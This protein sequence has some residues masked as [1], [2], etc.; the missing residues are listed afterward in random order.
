MSPNIDKSTLSFNRYFPLFLDVP[1][2][3]T[4]KADLIVLSSNKRMEIV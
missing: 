3:L 1:F 2:K 4:E